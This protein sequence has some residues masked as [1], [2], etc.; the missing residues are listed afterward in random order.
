MTAPIDWSA[1]SS[2]IIVRVIKRVGTADRPALLAAIQEACPY[3]ERQPYQSLV[4]AREVK[5]HLALVEQGRFE[6]PQP[7]GVQRPLFDG[8]VA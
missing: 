3:G 4:W 5:K 7:T 1:Q 8:G 2:G 6:P